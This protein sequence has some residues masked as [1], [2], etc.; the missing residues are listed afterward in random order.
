[1]LRTFESCRPVLASS[2]WVDATALVVGDVELAADVSV[3]PMTVVRGDV[4]HV[5]IGARTNIQDGTIIHVAHDRE[6]VQKGFPTLI[7]EDC[8]IGH[9]AIVH[10]CTVGDACLIGMAATV[11]D[12]AV[13]EDEVILAAGALV[14]PG[15]RLESG[16][17]YVGSPAR[18]QRCLSD[19]EREFLRYSAAHYVK[20]KNRHRYG[21]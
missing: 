12:G 13:L 6:G 2:A 9:R 14:P 1:M 16:H 11:M 10:A 20:L 5:R 8:T 7:G 17:L 19:K 15:K 21:R 18:M 4:N 3:W